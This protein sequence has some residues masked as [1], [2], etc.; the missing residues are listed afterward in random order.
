MAPERV[1]EIEEFLEKNEKLAK[2]FKS[3]QS[4]TLMKELEDI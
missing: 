4:S 3:H 2:L 1:R